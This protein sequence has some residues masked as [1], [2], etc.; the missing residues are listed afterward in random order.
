[1]KIKTIAEEFEEFLAAVVRPKSPEERLLNQQAFYAGVLVV[2]GIVER[3]SKLPDKAQQ[4]IFLSIWRELQEFGDTATR[5]A[6][7][8]KYVKQR[9][10]ANHQLSPK[11]E[12]LLRRLK[13]TGF[14]LDTCLATLDM[15]AP[16]QELAEHA[17]QVFRHHLKFSTPRIALL[18]TLVELKKHQ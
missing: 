1:M 7:A 17:K 16:P 9:P 6:D 15:L 18:T 12:P 10:P 14:T 11:Y 4:K 3:M 8:I 13:E 2:V 5:T